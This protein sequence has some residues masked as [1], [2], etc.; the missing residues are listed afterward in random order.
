MSD[1]QTLKANKSASTGG[2]GDNVLLSAFHEIG[3]VLRENIRNS[4]M[5]IVLI[6][7]VII[8]AIWSGGAFIS[9]F[10]LTNLVTQTAVVG[11]MACGMT[12]VIIIRHI[13]LSV[14]YMCGFLGAMAAI[15]MMQLNL[16]SGLSIII[17]LAIGAAIGLVIGILV[18]KV[19]IPAFVV[20][21]G[22][23]IVGHG[24]ELL[25]TSS[26]GT[27]SINNKFFNALGT[28]YIPSFTKIGGLKDTTVIIGLIL[29]VLYIVLQIR[30]RLRQHR[31]SFAVEPMWWFI[32][33]LV[34]LCALIGFLTYRF[35]QLNGISW[36][37]II[38]GVVTLVVSTIQTRTRFG[39]HVYGTGGNPEAAELSGVS[40]ARVTIIVFVIM[41]LL[42]ALAG[43]LLA[44][45]MVSA[46]PTAGVGFELLVIAGCFIGGC[47]PAGGIGKVTGS[48][49]GALIM[50]SLVNG[51]TLKGVNISWQ[52]IIQGAILVLA[53][54]FDVLSRRIAAANALSASTSASADD[55]MTP[56][57]EDLA[58]AGGGPVA[59]VA[60]QVNP[61]VQPAAGTAT[62]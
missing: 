27:I 23:M 19:G 6:A 55:Q 53:V 48:V 25:A 9:A 15:F 50:Q 29:I 44:S 26:H 34:L 12:L 2:N 21:L 40:V 31:Y 10:N 43:I 57:V 39:R 42:V 59:A 4:V 45:R 36:A 49:I 61:P 24:L 3:R 1:T 41:G 30:G 13:D 18:G 60:A 16:P 37:L 47:S 7:I 8:F 33:K 62:P 5:F 22:A 52:Y 46:S 38:L 58:L 32:L 35:A 20:T 17:V 14:G 11:I 56:P 28:G 51:M 54:L